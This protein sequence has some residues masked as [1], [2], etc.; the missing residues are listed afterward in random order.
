[1]DVEPMRVAPVAAAVLARNFR[2]FIERPTSVLATSHYRTQHSS[3][4]I[5]VALS[6]PSE[7]P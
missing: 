6:P 4:K 7:K 3:F 5:Q 2:R 1:M